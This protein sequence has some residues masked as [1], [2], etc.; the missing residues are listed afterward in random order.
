MRALLQRYRELVFVAALLAAPLA[1]YMVRGRKPARLNLLDRAIIQLTAPV[2]RMIVGVA[3]AMVDVFQGYVWLRKVRFENL[4]LRRTVVR[5]RSEVDSAHEIRLENER[6]RKLLALRD[7]LGPV[8]T[9]PAQVVAVGASPLSHSL[10][11]ARGLRDGLV[12]GA[13]VISAEGV[14]GTIAQLADGY[15]DVQLVTSPFSAISALNQRTRGRSTVKGTGDVTRCKLEYA[16][17]TDEIL[18]SDVLVT[19][20]GAGHFPKG[21]RLGRVTEIVKKP[22]GLFQQARVIPAVDFSR[23][24]EVLVVLAPPE[25]QIPQA[26]PRAAVERGKP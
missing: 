21:L 15:A 12:R 4:E 25:P 11:I 10:R 6:L 22:Y 18:E 5:Q 1:V 7:S 13:P 20:G 26:L 9:M 8:P 19:A 16:L 2:E 14:V 17:R 24:D 23:L 3:G